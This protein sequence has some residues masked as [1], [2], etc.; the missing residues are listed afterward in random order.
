MLE[1]I[2]LLEELQQID[3]R[4][5]EHGQSA[6]KFP[7]RLREMR[8]HLQRIENLLADERL[9][10]AEAE[11]LHNEQERELRVEEEQISKAKHK[12]QQVRNQKEYSATNKEVETLRKMANDRAE[13]VLKLMEAVE[14]LR[15]SVREHDGELTELRRQVAAEEKLAQEQTA[16]IEAQLVEVRKT[17]DALAIRVRP[18]LMKRYQAV[19]AKRELAV[20]PVRNGTCAG[21]HMNIPPQ[22]YNQLI[23][24]E[25]LFVCPLCLRIIY[26]EPDPKNAAKA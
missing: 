1:Q 13:E 19:R 25:Q 18:D 5:H 22:L 3:A 17:R 12:L 9:R 7:A 15:G 8:D 21:C 16:S 4:I 14:Q 6:A 11:R 20:V 2:R 26:Y 23:R 10:L 24:G